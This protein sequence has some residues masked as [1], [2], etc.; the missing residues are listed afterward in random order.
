MKKLL[1]ATSV[2]FAFSSAYAQKPMGKQN[3][4]AFVS[5]YQSK[6]SDAK[7]SPSKPASVSSEA[8]PNVKPVGPSTKPAP[9]SAKPNVK[10]VGKQPAKPAPVVSKV[11][12]IKGA[13][14]VGPSS[15]RATQSTVVTV[16]AKERPS[17]E[18]EKKEVKAKKPVEINEKSP[19]DSDF[20]KGWT[21]GFKKTYQQAKVEFNRIPRCEN[22]GKCR[23]YACGYEAGINK[24]YSMLKN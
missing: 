17:S 12:P 11:S 2:L 15:N 13:K 19:I 16:T 9:V 1:I 20:C 14:P 21:D 5:K 23:G 22:D 7:P 10:P 18:I 8:K 3:V 4:N 6:T 24:A